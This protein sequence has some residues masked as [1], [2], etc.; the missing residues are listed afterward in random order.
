[1]RVDWR[2]LHA[3]AALHSFLHSLRRTTDG[4]TAGVTAGETALLEEARRIDALEDRARSRR[5]ENLPLTL[6]FPSA[7]ALSPHPPPPQNALPGSGPSDGRGK[8]GPRLDVFWLVG[9]EGAYWPDIVGEQLWEMGESSGFLPSLGAV[10]VIAQGSQPFRLPWRDG[11]FPPP[12]SGRAQGS[13]GPL[14]NHAKSASKDSKDRW[15]S[16]DGWYA[17]VGGE[18]REEERAKF[19]V[20][21]L[22]REGWAQFEFPAL[23]RLWDH[24]GREGGRGRVVL[25]IHSKGAQSASGGLRELQ[26][27]LALFQFQEAS[28]HTYICICVCVCVCV[29]AT[30]HVLDRYTAFYK[31]HCVDKYKM[32]TPV[33][34]CE[35][36]VWLETT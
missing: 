11:S 32:V 21:H 14:H 8:A 30:A 31:M 17:K 10:H 23:S 6:P 35:H 24:C 9:C 12:E 33:Q 16:G 4:E 18:W 1:M 20:T 25:Y 27:R 7:E 34:T 26:V 28:T 2:P 36:D 29:F 13:N 3:T 5:L 19:D 15:G 22:G